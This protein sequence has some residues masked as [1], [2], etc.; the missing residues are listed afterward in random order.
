MNI[1]VIG[2]YGLYTHL[3][4]S[5]IHSQV[6]EFVQKGHRVRVIIPIPVG[7]VRQNRRMGPALDIQTA[8]GVEL[9]YVRY[10]SMSNAG[11]HCFNAQSA[12]FAVRTC[13]NRILQDFVPDIIHAHTLML[14]GRIGAMLKKKLECPLVITTH[15]SDTFVPFAAGETAELKKYADP[16]DMVICVSSLLKRCMEECGV[17]APTRIIF[18]GFRVA[19]HESCEKDPLAIVQA[20][21]LVARKKADVTIRA[22]GKLLEKYPN[23]TLKIIGSGAEE[24]RFRALSRELGLQDKVEFTGYLPNPVLLEELAKAQFF[25]MPSVREGFGIV[26]LEAMANGCIAIGTEGEGIADLIEPGKNG[27]LV[28]PDDPEAI[29]CVID[30]CIQDPQ[31]AREIAQQGH[32]DAVGLTWERNAAEYISLFESLLKQDI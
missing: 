9:Y 26:Y 18:N 1:L 4:A 20:G 12:S 8:D 28:P 7:K 23:A 10:L 3:S 15:G 11:K 21:Y 16:A 6:K 13:L 14:D 30:Q 32:D 17:S 25:V 22:Y 2:H 24:A 31:W 29:V 27:F 5:Y 19:E